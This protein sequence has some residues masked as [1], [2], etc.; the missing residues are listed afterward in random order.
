MWTHLKI[1]EPGVGSTSCSPGKERFS[2]PRRTVEEDPLGCTKEPR[3]RQ[4]VSRSTE[5][6]DDGVK[7]VG[8]HFLQA[9]NAGPGGLQCWGVH[10]AHCDAYLIVGEFGQRIDPKEPENLH[11]LWVLRHW[12]V[13]RMVF[14]WIY[15]LVIQVKENFQPFWWICA[16]NAFILSLWPRPKW[17]N[18][19]HFRVN[20]SAD[21]W[22]L[23]VFRS[24][25]SRRDSLT[26]LIWCIHTCM[27][28]QESQI[29]WQNNY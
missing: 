16:S 20:H 14:W 21:L 22:S 4:K 7:Q 28:H 5:G 29:T 23:E 6:Q 3:T 2:T 13:V 1:E 11:G 12:K 10:E 9:P 17:P 25:W 18:G 27:I 26:A 15:D 24:A 8:H 19:V